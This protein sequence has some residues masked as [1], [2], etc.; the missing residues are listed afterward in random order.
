MSETTQKSIK[1]AL[2]YAAFFAAYAL[3]FAF[4][5]WI[6]ASVVANEWVFPHLSPV[7]NGQNAFA[8]VFLGVA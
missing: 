1:K 4:I 7:L 5:W 6:V 2:K 3:A 8:G